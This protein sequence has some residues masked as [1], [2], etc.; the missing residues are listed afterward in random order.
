MPAVATAA[1]S[2]VLTSTQ[3]CPMASLG[4]L[5]LWCRVSVTSLQVAGTASSVLSYCMRSLPLISSLQGSAACAHGAASSAPSSAA[6]LKPWRRRL[7]VVSF[8][9][10]LSLGLKSVRHAQAL[11]H[12]RTGGGV[13]QELF[14]LRIQVVLDRERGERRLVEAG[15]DQLLLARVGVD[16]AHREDSREARLELLGVHLEGTFLQRQPPVGNRAELGMQT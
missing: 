6:A 8:I 1:R 3:S 10:V 7:I 15:Q 2:G 5:P 4:S 14:L 13:L 12:H 11:V 9:A 16:V